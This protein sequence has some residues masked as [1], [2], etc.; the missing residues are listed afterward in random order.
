MSFLVE[1]MRNPLTVGAVQASGSA[2]AEVATATVP[3]TGSPVVLELGPGTGA[4]TAPVQR[5]LAGSG[6]HIAIELNPRFAAKL[7]MLHPAVDVVTGNAAALRGVLAQRGVDSVDV[8]ISGLPWAA[9]DRKLQQ[10]VLSEVVAVM[11]PAGVFTTFAYVHARWA[12]PARRLLRSLQDRFEEVVVS[13]TVW[14]NLPPAL[15]YFCR[16]PVPVTTE[17]RRD[18]AVAASGSADGQTF[19]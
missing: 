14:K 15:V 8:V 10:D 17:E 18:S 12:P 5:R 13:R 1:F 19:H 16:R 2:L 11:H 9:F 3:A 6:R 7:A 4:F